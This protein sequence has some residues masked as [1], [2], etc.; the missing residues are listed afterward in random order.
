MIGLTPSVTQYGTTVPGTTS[1]GQK[2][3]NRGM[4]TRNGSFWVPSILKVR[5]RLRPYAPDMIPCTST[6]IMECEACKYFLSLHEGF[7][8]R[9]FIGTQVYLIIVVASR[10][11]LT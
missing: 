1:I 9:Y 7:H 5:T 6:G 3:Q 2:S 8:V 11:H 4:P 10:K